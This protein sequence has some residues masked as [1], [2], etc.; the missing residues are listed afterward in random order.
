[1]AFSTVYEEFATI[2]RKGRVRTAIV[3]V[4]RVRKLDI[5]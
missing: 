1:M 5:M 2:I 3:A 4:D